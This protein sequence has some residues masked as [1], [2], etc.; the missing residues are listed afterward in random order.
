MNLTEFTV[1]C[2]IIAIILVEKDKIKI[3]LR[4][5]IMKKFIFASIIFI[6]PLCGAQTYEVGDHELF[7]M[8][9]AYTMPAGKSYFA[10]YELF[11]LNYTA[12]VTSST[13]VGA[14]TLF[15]IVKDFLETFTVGIKQ[16]YLR[17]PSFQGAVWGT[18]TPKIGGFTLGNVFSIGKPSNGIHAGIGAAIETEETSKWEVFYMLGYRYDAS[19]KVSLIAEYSNFHSLI[20]EDFKGLISIGVRF[21]VNTISWELAGVRPLESTGDFLFFPLLKATILL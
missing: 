19:K 18:Y 17:I 10:N 12:G 2:I 3:S 6:S 14:F 21:R 13:H 8:P 9:T 15:P 7:I 20:E 16:N 11:F 4:R 5:Q 1:F